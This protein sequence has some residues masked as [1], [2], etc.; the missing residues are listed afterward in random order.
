MTNSPSHSA[1]VDIAAVLSLLSNPEVAAA[2]A[3]ATAGPAQPAPIPTV[4][5]YLP[6][7]QQAARSTISRTYTSY[8]RLLVEHL[9]HKRLD[10]VRTTDLRALANTART[11]A[12][13]RRNSRGG[14]SAEENCVAAV[15]AFFRCAVE[16]GYLEVNPA[17]A[18]DKPR[19]LPSPRRALTAQEYAEL[20]AVTRSGGDD[21]VLDTL[22]L[23]FHS[24]TGARRG[25]A[26]SLTLADL[27]ESACQVRL[28]EKGGTSRWQPV[29]ATLL[30]ALTQHA[31]VR[32]AT[33]P[34]DSVFRYRPRKGSN[35]G[36]P[37]TQRRYNTLTNRWQRALPWAR[38]Y[39]VSPHWLRHTAVTAAERISGS[40]GVARAFAGHAMPDD[41]T[42]TYIKAGPAEVATVV[43]R[44]SGEPHPL[45]PNP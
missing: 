13:K 16:D 41:A 3:A 36:A 29:S 25:G 15:R 28:H 22:L 42:T 33:Q 39:G 34:G 43:A 19:R 11:G 10:Q 4:A 31:A 32:G 45:A 21:P 27:D 37:L 7:V 20:D 24:E 14:V 5:D 35:V 23:R 1:P 6:T 8:W 2:V 9:G 17:A 12:R 30:A 44:L 38:T 18:V 40:Y 26:L